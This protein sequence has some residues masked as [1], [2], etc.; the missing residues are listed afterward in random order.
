MH[1]PSLDPTSSHSSTTNTSAASV[2]GDTYGQMWQPGTISQ[3]SPPSLYMFRLQFLLIIANTKL[4]SFATLLILAQIPPPFTLPPVPGS[5]SSIPLTPNPPTSVEI[6]AYPPATQDAK[7]PESGPARHGRRTERWLSGF[8]GRLGIQ[9]RKK[10]T[11]FRAAKD[12]Q[13]VPE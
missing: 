12:E 7:P 11:R 5:F 9:K 13:V 10:P 4:I 1:Q 2:S 8:K 3:S 6:P